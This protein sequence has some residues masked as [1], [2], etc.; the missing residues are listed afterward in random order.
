MSQLASRTTYPNL[1]G[2]NEVFVAPSVVSESEQAELVHWIEEQLAREQLS[3][4]PLDPHMHV[5]AFYAEGGEPTLFARHP[6]RLPAHMWI[7]TCGSTALPPACWAIRN[8]VLEWLELEGLRDDPYK[9]TF[10]T[11]ITRD[12]E[13]ATHRD[14]RLQVDG[15]TYL[16]LRCNVLLQRP[17]VGGMPVISRRELDIA[18][19]G[20]WVFFPTELV[21]SATSVQGSRARATL[22]FGVLVTPAQLRDRRF[23]QSWSGDFV[24]PSVGAQR[25]VDVILASPDEVFSVHDVATALGRVPRDIWPAIIRLQRAGC[26]ESMSAANA[27]HGQ[28]I[29]L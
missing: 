12:G 15:E 2:T 23:R 5:S 8:R 26:I 19:R 17:Q 27:R 7:P 28:V 25:V 22:S 14:F 11:H 6:D 16:I 29:A 10:L 3:Q 21:H 18:E 4:N 13:V 9:G 1:L 24:A 20:C